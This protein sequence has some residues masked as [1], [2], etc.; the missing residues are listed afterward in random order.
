MTDILIIED[1]EE[2]GNLVRDFLKRE[3]Y[4]VQLARSAEEGLELIGKAAFKMLLLDVMLPGMN[5][6]ETLQEIRKEQKLPVLMMSAKTDEQSKVLGYEVGADDYIDKPFSFQVLGLKIKALM[7][8]TYDL[9]EDR[10]LLTYGNIAL[11]VASKTVYK[12]DEPVQI[13]G[14]E[15]ELLEYMMRHPEAVLKKEKLF[16]EIWGVDCFSDLGSLNVHI[17]WLREKLED[18]PKNPKLIR[19]VWRVGYQ[20]GGTEN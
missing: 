13:T 16:D 6:Y 4:S 14:K 11:D 1:N 3:G 20:F 7:K 2:L 19:T 9:A 8:R 5:G 15:F 12:N 17:R 18:D 10:Q